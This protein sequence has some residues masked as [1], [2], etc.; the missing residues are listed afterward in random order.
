MNLHRNIKARK[1]TVNPCNVFPVS[2]SFSALT[3]D[4]SRDGIAIAAGTTAATFAR[5]VFVAA[6]VVPATGTSSGDGVS[7]VDNPSTDRWQN[8]P[9]V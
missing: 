2:S 1:K 5:A 9:A 7:A 8:N 3:G 6:T 4:I